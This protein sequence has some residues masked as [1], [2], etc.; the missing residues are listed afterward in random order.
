MLYSRFIIP[1]IKAALK[2]T[3]VI[4]LTGARQTGKT[5]LV[6][7]IAKEIH[8]AV[9][10]TLD[11]LTLRGAAQADPQG[12]LAQTSGPIVIDEI[13]LAPELLSAIKIAVDK[14]RQPGRFI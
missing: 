4:L 1:Q 9:Y 6:K 2:D 10:F 11:D 8:P 5:T 7:K 13:Q 14:D 12:F 3:P